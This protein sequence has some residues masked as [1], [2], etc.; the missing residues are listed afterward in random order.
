[1]SHSQVRHDNNW[2]LARGSKGIILNFN[3][4]SLHVIQVP[5][6]SM[7]TVEAN[8]SMSDSLG[9]LIFYSNNCFIANS[10]KTIV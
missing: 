3:D 8:V 7:R 2:V 4:D 6:L 1:M 5:Q 10:N 9:N